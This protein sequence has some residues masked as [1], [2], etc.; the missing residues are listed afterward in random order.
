MR[1]IYE[2]NVRK[3]AWKQIICPKLPISVQ[4]DGEFIQNDVNDVWDKKDKSGFSSPG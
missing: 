3:T 4:M 1:L 2:D